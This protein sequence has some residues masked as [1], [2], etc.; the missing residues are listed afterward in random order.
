[1]PS[2][3]ATLAV[4]LAAAANALAQSEVQSEATTVDAQKI[5]GVSD[6]EVSARGAAEI[7]RGD[8][9]IFGEFLRYN[10]EFGEIEGQG[11]VR[12]QSGPDR[13]F[14]PSLHYDT[15]EDTGTF[16]QPGFLLQRERP[17]RGTADRIE[18][19]GRNRFRLVNA[20]FTTCKPGQDDWFLE[21]SQLD[22]DYDA[23]EGHARRPRLRFF[24]HT[25]LAF[26]A[27]GFPLENR[28]RSGVLT[29]YYSQTSTRGL[30]FGLP[31]YWNIAPEQDATF[32]PVYMAR[33]G[34]QL[35]NHY[36]Y[37]G[38]PYAG[39]LRYEYL[40]DDPVFGR[41]RTGM[42]WAHLQNLRPGTTVQVDYNKVS[43]DR[44]FV[45]LASQVKQV[46]VGN[47]PQDF[48]LTQ[49]AG[50]PGAGNFTGL[51]RMQRF[52]TL[53]DPLAPIVP[54]YHRLPQINASANYND[55]AGRFDTVLPGEFVRFVHPTLTEGTRATFGPTFAVPRLRPGW[56]VTPKAGVRHTTYQLDNAATGEPANPSVTVPWLSVDSG[57][58][59][60]RNAR[61]FGDAL[62]QTL[63]PR[64][65]YVFVPYRKQDHI[66]LFDTTLADFNYPQL[67]T[68]NRFIGGDRF[69]DANQA[70][71]ALTTRF[72]QAS[73]Q[74][75]FRATLG[76]RFYFQD[77][78]V[79]LSQGSTLR[80]AS[81]SDVLASIGG[82]MYQNFTFDATTQYN[83]YKSR[84]ERYGVS[85]RYAPEIAKVINASYRFQR[86]ILRQV[87]ISGQWPVTAGWYGVGRYNYSLL[88]N[89]LLE[90]LAGAE[91]NAGCWIFRF[92]VQR[93]Q[94]A[95]QVS[96]TA[97]IFQLEFSGVGQIGTA[98]AVQLLRRDVPGYSVINRTDPAL[99]A[100]SARPRLPFEQV[101]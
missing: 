50:L 17:A 75:A 51:A 53:Q 20:R 52:Q 18:F 12:L 56:Y 6:L 32:T 25:I 13:F 69:G 83:P 64:L 73:G 40:P 41:T 34:F 39:E 91:Y 94:A 8:V 78:R 89:R 42:S 37:L 19:L 76:Q 84:A 80:L 55:V 36:R 81:E 99:A 92:V 93:I 44:Y 82:R 46:S 54:P 62:T 35:K 100:P 96:S 1:M 49:T 57:L 38:R 63:E 48:I 74:E 31:F 86:D 11:G 58:V 87:D 72:L 33:R 45:D 101:F 7:Q 97:L 98:E 61:W 43:D 29:P 30:E 88:D 95:A 85:M 5:E 47:L 10:R 2:R 66:P 9:T 71:V 14:G 65:F 67:F 28:R 21:A 3:L 22:L 4:A 15:L 27:A 24:D 77:E 79:A 23:D 90:G 16:E 68:E 59:F 60:E 26:P 70:T